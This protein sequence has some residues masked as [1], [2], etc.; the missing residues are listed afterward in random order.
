MSFAPTGTITFL[1]TDIEGSTSLWEQHPDAMRAALTRHDALANDII[2]GHGGTL[3][4]SRGEGDSLFAVF[5]TATE[6]LA[7][8]CSLQQAFLVEPWPPET[9]LRIRMALHTGEA[10]LREGDYYGAA[11]NRCARLRA[12][13][14]GGQV[15]LSQTTYALTRDHLPPNVS[16]HALG[17]HRLR[18]LTRPETVYQ[19]LHPDLPSDA[20]PLLSLDNPGLPNN[21]PQQPTSFVGRE[22][23]VAEVKER[24]TRSRLVTLA[25]S[26]GA[27]KSRLS[28]QVA[29]GRFSTGFPTASGW[30]NWRRLQTPSW[31]PRLWPRCS[32]YVRSRAGHSSKLCHML[33]MNLNCGGCPRACLQQQWTAKLQVKLTL[34]L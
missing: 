8:A 27:G 16:L 18:D 4:K 17:E 32:E 24:I 23:E 6:A 28:L 33:L 21:L 31:C 1:F 22:K 10:D 26:G 34:L 2:A 20:P 15:L 11:V 19:L 12:V 13:A 25:G 9:P 29:A 5:P 14:H 7:A 3:V 30:W